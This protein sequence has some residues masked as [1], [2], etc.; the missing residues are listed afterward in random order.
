M[1]YNIIDVAKDHLKGQVVWASV[2]K[3]NSRLEVCKK[4][5]R[6]FVPPALKKISNLTGTCKVCGCAVDLKV[7]YEKSEC[8]IRKW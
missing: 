5:D 1:G 2:E 3:K 7:K 4:C 6:L 8:P